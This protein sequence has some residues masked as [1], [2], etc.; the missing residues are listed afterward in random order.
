MPDDQA[1]KVADRFGQMADSWTMFAQQA[2]HDWANMRFQKKKTPDG[3][4][5]RSRK[6]FE[7]FRRAVYEMHKMY[8]ENAML[9]LA[10]AKEIRTG[11]RQDLD[12]KKGGIFGNTK[13]I[14][15]ENFKLLKP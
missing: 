8:K 6:E 13:N 4:G 12:I 10:V 5:H 11:E 7:S 15:A 3:P 9:C 1:K 2:Y 14:I